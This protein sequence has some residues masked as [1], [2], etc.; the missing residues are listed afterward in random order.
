MVGC[1]V[2][3]LDE[4]VVA[5]G[6]VA[7]AVDVGGVDADG[8]L[9]GLRTTSSDEPPHAASA[10][11][12][13]PAVTSA[14]VRRAA[15][16]RKATVHSSEIEVLSPG[17]ARERPRPPNLGHPDDLTLIARTVRGL[18]SVEAALHLAGA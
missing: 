11:T 8:R 14:V 16:G 5:G 12:A 1:R 9:V 10:A 2:T 6:V 4:A 15:H 18:S 7:G 17:T 3:G 13:R